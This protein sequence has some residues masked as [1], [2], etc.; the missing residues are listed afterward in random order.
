MGRVFH[1]GDWKLDASPIIGNPAT[2]EQLAAIGD[3]GVEVL[4]CDSTNVFNNE[5]SGSESSV[6]IGLSETVAKA[7]GRVLVTS[8]AS[9]AARLVTL[10]E[11]AKESG[12]KLCV[13]W[14]FAR[15]HPEG[16]PRLRVLQRLPGDDRSRRRDA[17]AAR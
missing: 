16:R 4:V 15:P 12:R 5:A 2:A 6:W 13:D 9:N 17:A 8:F 10:G 1:T 3:D 7:K 11:V 14:P